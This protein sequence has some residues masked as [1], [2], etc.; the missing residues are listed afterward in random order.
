MVHSFSRVIVV[1][2]VAVVAAMEAVM[3]RKMMPFEHAD[4][5]INIRK[6]C[7]AHAETINYTNE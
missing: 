1:V 7:G 5:S 3:V 4:P 6:S 2:V